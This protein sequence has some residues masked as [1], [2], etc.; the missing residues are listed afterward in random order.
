VLDTSYI[1]TILDNIRMIRGSLYTHIHKYTELPKDRSK[2][3]GI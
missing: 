1:D 2:V 3:F